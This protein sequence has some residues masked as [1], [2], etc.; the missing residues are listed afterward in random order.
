MVHKL[1]KSEGEAQ[2]QG[3][4]MVVNPWLPQLIGYTLKRIGS[5]GP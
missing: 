2:G 3:L 1:P 4:F 5:V